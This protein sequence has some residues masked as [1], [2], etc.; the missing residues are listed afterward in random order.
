M[1]KIEIKEV[2][3]QEINR[4]KTKALKELETI[5]EAKR[6]VKVADKKKYNALQSKIKRLQHELDTHKQTYGKIIATQKE[7][8]VLLNADAEIQPQ[9]EILVETEEPYEELVDIYCYDKVKEGTE[10]KHLKFTNHYNKP[11]SYHLLNEHG[12]LFIDE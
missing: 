9:T 2:L 5:Q 8:L 3:L 10:I 1:I 7:Q 12:E 6:N 4:R 11:V